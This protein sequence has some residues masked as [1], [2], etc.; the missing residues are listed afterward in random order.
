MLKR[1]EL[2]ITTKLWYISNSFLHTRLTACGCSLILDQTF[3]FLYI[4]RCTFHQREDVLSCCQESL[5][6]LQLDYLDLYLVHTPIAMKKEAK[7]PGFT[8]DDILGYNPDT[9]ADTWKV[10]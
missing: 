8:Q 7:F 2:F 1:E 4:F 3:S 10:L 5:K 9:E 6:N